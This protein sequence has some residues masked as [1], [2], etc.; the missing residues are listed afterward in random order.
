MEIT[1]ID[2]WGNSEFVGMNGIEFFDE[3][4]Q[5]LSVHQIKLINKEN[6]EIIDKLT[7]EPFIT[8]DESK[9]WKY[10]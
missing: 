9:I 7:R 4:G 2:N 10:Q 1:I 5:R 8:N 3:N 6:E